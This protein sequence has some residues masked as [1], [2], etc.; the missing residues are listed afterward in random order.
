MANRL[1]NIRL[2]TVRGPL[3]VLKNTAVSCSI[4]AALKNKSEGEFLV[5]AP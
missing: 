4:S 3:S 2:H 1:R 5:S